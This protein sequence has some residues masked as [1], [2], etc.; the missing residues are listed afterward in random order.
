MEASKASIPTHKRT[1]NFGVEVPKTWK[2]IIRID[3]VPGA[4]LWQDTVKMES[5]ALIF[6]GCFDFKPPKITT[7]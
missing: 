3:D 5:F 4:T 6:H 1:F 2:G 7:L